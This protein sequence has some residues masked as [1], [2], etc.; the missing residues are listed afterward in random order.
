MASCSGARTE[1]RTWKSR[2]ARRERPALPVNPSSEQI[3]E[4]GALAG[5]AD[6]GPLVMLN[7][8]RYRERAAYAVVPPGGG[9]AAVSGLEAYQR[10]GMTALK[11]LARVGGE[12]LWSTHATM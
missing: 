7:L 12:V 2:C 5:T 11:V 9:L 6:D 10:Y 3:A 8:N 1:S 4:L